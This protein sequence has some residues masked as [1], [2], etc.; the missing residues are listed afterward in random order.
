MNQAYLNLVKNAMHAC[1]FINIVRVKI[2]R[3]TKMTPPISNNKQTTKTEITKDN[4]GLRP[5]HQPLAKQYVAFHSSKER[6][7]LKLKNN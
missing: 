3:E 7:L 6:I 5:A 4:D 1:T 2:H